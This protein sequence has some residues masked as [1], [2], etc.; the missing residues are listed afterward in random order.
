MVAALV[1]GV[2]LII[3]SFI[4]YIM[5]RKYLRSDDF[6]VMAGEET[7]K[8]LKAKSGEFEE[9]QWEG[10]SV[11]SKSFSADGGADAFFSRLKAH[12]V[13]ANVSLKGVRKGYWLIPN[14]EIK[15][16][17]FAVTDTPNKVGPSSVLPDPEP[18]EELE[19]DGD[20]GGLFSGIIP[21]EVKIEEVKVDETRFNI[22]TATSDIRARGIELLIAPMVGSDE[23]YSIAGN[24]GQL[25][26]NLLP[27]LKVNE[28]NLHLGQEERIYI[29][30]VGVSFYDSARAQL[31]GEAHFEDDKPYLDLNGGVSGIMLDEVLPPDA[32]KK[33]LGQVNGDFALKTESSGELVVSGDLNLKNGS[34]EALPVLRELDAMTRTTHFTKLNLTNVEVEFEKRGA[35]LQLKDVLFESA[36]LTCLKGHMVRDANGIPTGMYMLG[37]SPDTIKWMPIV[38]KKVVEQVF[39]VPH[40]EAFSKVFP[41]VASSG[42][43]MPPQGYLWAVARIDPTSP[44]PYTADIRRQLID[45]G[46]LAIWAELQ[47]LPDNV[48]KAAGTVAEAAETQGEDIIK[49]LAEE[50]FGTETLGLSTDLIEKLST[51]LN[52][53]DIFED[54]TVVPMN[55]IEGGFDIINDLNPLAPKPK[56]RTNVTPTPTG[57]K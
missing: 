39:R 46:G 14:V 22:V 49:M 52:I 23:N 1:T 32:A 18:E 45:A 26:I 9:F 40:S 13:R 50:G 27:K 54:G 48:I 38:R 55:I 11:Y 25:K 19:D 57:T 8:A 15:R 41:G 20:G 24:G 3:F 34:L 16:I 10:R 29:D 2:G 17:D 47:G 7:S 42:I 28:F 6:R 21:T 51:E 53:E 37:V 33:L 12:E 30:H 56:P 44:D 43:E 35:E 36:G 31:S 5:V 4:G